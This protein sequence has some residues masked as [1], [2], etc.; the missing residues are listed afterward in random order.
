MDGWAKWQNS[1]GR[2]LIVSVQGME[3]DAMA[4]SCLTDLVL[5]GDKRRRVRERVFVRSPLTRFLLQPSG[6]LISVMNQAR[7]GRSVWGWVWLSDY[8]AGI[9][10][11]VHLNARIRFLWVGEM[12]KVF[13]PWSN[14]SRKMWHHFIRDNISLTP[15]PFCFTNNSYLLLRNKSQVFRRFVLKKPGL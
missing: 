1:Q 12:K 10:H 4:S 3:L 5:P 6:G 13:V 14:F 11:L 9:F 7:A 2:M 8:S 15:P